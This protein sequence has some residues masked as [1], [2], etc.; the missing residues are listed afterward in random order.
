MWFIP[1]GWVGCLALFYIMGLCFADLDCIVI[2][3]DC[4][5]RVGIGSKVE[6]CHVRHS[7][8]YQCH[9]PST[10]DPSRKAGQGMAQS[11]AQL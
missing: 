11:W 7:G 2:C 9:T 1:T 6:S 10:V 4:S 3:A 5:S 8:M